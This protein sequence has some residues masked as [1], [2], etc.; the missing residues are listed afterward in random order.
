MTT[1]CFRLSSTDSRS[2]T[3]FKI[4]VSHV[5]TTSPPSIRCSAIS[6]SG[7]G[8]F[9]LFS[10]LMAKPTSSAVRNAED[11]PPYPVTAQHPL[12][13]VT[14]AAQEIHPLTWPG[15]WNTEPILP[16]ETVD[17]WWPPHLLLTL[18]ICSS[19]Y[20]A[21]WNDSLPQLQTLY[22]SLWIL[23][24]SA[25]AA[26]NLTLFLT[27]LRNLP[28]SFRWTQP[29]SFHALRADLL[30]AHKVERAWGGV[31]NFNP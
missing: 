10:F 18:S 9:L 7:T 1:P 28:F 27:A 12:S 21:V 31:P 25:L 26:Q 13:V 4:P 14:P 19:S 20:Q 24:L 29:A 5:V 23:I 22:L 6:L 11:N 16:S 8:A 3:V 15:Y 17:W 30:S 2:I